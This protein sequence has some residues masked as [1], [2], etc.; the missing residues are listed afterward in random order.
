MSKLYKVV[1]R[2]EIEPEKEN[3][4]LIQ[5]LRNY[6]KLSAENEDEL[7]SGKTFIL[8]DKQPYKSAIATVAN[9][10]KVGVI[11]YVE[12]QN[13]T[14]EIPE[15]SLSQSKVAEDCSKSSL[16]AGKEE[17][18]DSLKLASNELKDKGT[19]LKN[20]LSDVQKKAIESKTGILVQIRLYLESLTT[21]VSLKKP[22]RILL[23]PIM[24]S[25]VLV[26]SI[27]MFSGGNPVGSGL[28]SI[29]SENIENKRID[30]T[31]YQDVI[32]SAV[33]ELNSYDLAGWMLSSEYAKEKTGDKKE[34]LLIEL[35]SSAAF[36]YIASKDESNLLERIALGEVSEQ[37]LSRSWGHYH[38]QLEHII[39]YGIVEFFND[40]REVMAKYLASKVTPEYEKSRR[41]LD[42]KITTNE[43]RI[44]EVKKSIESIKERKSD[45]EQR[46]ANAKHNKTLISKPLRELAE[47]KLH[48]LSNKNLALEFTN[49]SD[50][51]TD[52]LEG[53]IR[54]KQG[55]VSLESYISS[56]PI[57]PRTK[58]ILNAREGRARTKPTNISE[59]EVA[60][61]FKGIN[62]TLPTFFKSTDL[63]KHN[64]KMS[65]DDPSSYDSFIQLARNDLNSANQTIEEITKNMDFQKNRLKEYEESKNLYILLMGDFIDPEHT[66]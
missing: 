37:E 51:H 18:A 7:F 50:F 17:L 42:K 62:L 3:E 8:K 66:M 6:F 55:E 25:L 24:I 39:E 30:L 53:V 27:V 31:D 33:E 36:H 61:T 10:L 20:K 26:I 1:F 34:Q 59:E 57:P 47:L 40:N 54:F 19:K 12:E 48:S 65:S 58:V 11:T 63:E 21:K 64:E 2:G 22:R 4:K 35:Y 41:Q 28:V 56:E 45:L 15:S 16:A 5:S 14:T 49:N 13:I 23:V 32:T 38:D 29:T 9:F 44:N 60:S 46:L 43:N 52:K